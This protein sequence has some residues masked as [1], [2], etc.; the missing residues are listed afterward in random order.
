MEVFARAVELGGFSAAARKFGMTP[1]AVSKLVARLEARLGARLVNR[2]TRRLQLTP[3]GQDFYDR[4]VRI[5]SDME[6]AERQAASGSCPRGHLRVNANLVFGRMHLL[7]LVPRFLELYPE[8]SLDVVLSDTVIDLMDERADIAIRVG[9]LSNP[10]LVARKLGT[11]RVAVVAA[12]SYLE[13]HGVPATPADLERHNRI[14]WTFSRSMRGWPF[15]V[16][17][18]VM[19]IP[20]AGNVRASDGDSACQLALAGVG[21]ARLGRFHIEAYIEAGQ[22][23][24]VLEDFH[25]GD[26][27]EI[28]AV[29]LGQSGLLP[30]R[31]RAFIDFLVEH[32]RSWPGLRG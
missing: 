28:N 12:P 14:G 9:P 5:L 23:V 32:A 2:S 19:M 24:P 16:D 30:A 29:Y 27:E 15:R 4:A 26:M 21:L 22:L 10:N 25:P 18:Q 7:P 31:A 17:G 11:S 3:E 20:P 13:K 6:E 1:S 8:V